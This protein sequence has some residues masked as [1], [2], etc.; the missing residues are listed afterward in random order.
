[1]IHR[2]EEVVGYGRGPGTSIAAPPPK[3]RP[4]F[5]ASPD[6]TSVKLAFLGCVLGLG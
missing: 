6:F 2:T 3:R 4:V 5:I 1:M